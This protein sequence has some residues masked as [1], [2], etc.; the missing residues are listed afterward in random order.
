MKILLACDRS[1]G[2][3]YPALDFARYLKEEHL[4]YKVI[5]HGLKK[6]DRAYLERQG[7]KCLGLDL[8]FRNIFIEALIR[9]FEALFLLI[10][11]AIMIFISVIFAIY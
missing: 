1:R 2:H 6:K 4:K 11:F 5:F 9:F 3:L 8:G 7:F 10:Y